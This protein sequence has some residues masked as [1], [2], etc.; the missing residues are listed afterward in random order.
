LDEGISVWLSAPKAQRQLYLVCR[1]HGA[2]AGAIWRG[3]ISGIFMGIQWDFDAV[4][5]GFM[6]DFDFLYRI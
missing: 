4:L 2:S 3:E 5:S 1:C 6:I